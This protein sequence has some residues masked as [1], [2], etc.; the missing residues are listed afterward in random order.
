MLDYPTHEMVA[1][2][3][4]Q[5]HAPDYPNPIPGTELNF[6]RITRLEREVARARDV[7][8]PLRP[9]PVSPS[10]PAAHPVAAQECIEH[11]PPSRI[12][13]FDCD[14]RPVHVQPGARRPC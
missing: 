7:S 4:R 5:P 11:D 12:R 1:S 6:P 9:D 13:S 2:G 8:R 10:E 3:S 14:R